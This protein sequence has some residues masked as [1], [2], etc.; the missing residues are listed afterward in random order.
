MS[1]YHLGT[2]YDFHLGLKPVL[3]FSKPYT[4]TTFIREKKNELHLLAQNDRKVKGRYLERK[5]RKE[6]S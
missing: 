2:V 3:S 5:G 6:K 1:I 4:F